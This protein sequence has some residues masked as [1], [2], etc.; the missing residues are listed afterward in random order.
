MSASERRGG[1]E[2]TTVGTHP[3]S[4]TSLAEPE[5]EIIDEWVDGVKECKDQVLYCVYHAQF[6]CVYNVHACKCVCTHGMHGP[7]CVS[8]CVCVCVR[9]CACVCVY[10]CTFGPSFWA[11][12][13][14]PSGT[15]T[16]TLRASKSFPTSKFPVWQSMDRAVEVLWTE[17]GSRHSMINV[18]AFPTVNTALSQTNWAIHKFPG[19]VTGETFVGH[20]SGRRL[21]LTTLTVFS[22]SAG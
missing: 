21:R 4:R 11:R 16:F 18:A 12:S 10:V 2:S 9:V 20:T 14:G 3:N 13:I 22:W 15:A 8:V 5:R 1:T 6:V 17:S 7:V 19:L